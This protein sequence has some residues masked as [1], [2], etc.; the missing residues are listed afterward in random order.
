[1]LNVSAPAFLAIS[2]A[3]LA[4]DPLRSIGATLTQLEASNRAIAS[5]YPETPPATT[6][7]T[8]ELDCFVFSLTV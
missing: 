3:E 5:P 1:V 6:A 2:A 4:S 8:A 7:V